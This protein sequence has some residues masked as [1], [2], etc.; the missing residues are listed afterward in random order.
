M[1]LSD[2]IT[3]QYLGKPVEVEDP[4]NSMQCM[5]WAFFACDRMGIPREAIRHL[6]AAQVFN[7]PNTVTRQFF[8]LVP[9][10]SDYVPPANSFA[11]WFANI[12]GLTGIA[13]HIAW[14]LSG[15]TQKT[16]RT[17]DENWNGQLKVTINNHTYPGN[18]N[19]VQMGF[20]VPK[21]NVEGTT[22]MAETVAQLEQRLLHGPG[23]IDEWTNK[24][25]QQGLELKSVQNQLD[26]ARAQVESQQEVINDL[27]KENVAFKDA[28]E[29][30]QRLVKELEAA[31][32]TSAPPASLPNTEPGYPS[33]VPVK[34]SFDLS[35]Y[36]K[37]IIALVGGAVTVATA[38]WGPSN[39]VLTAISTALTALGVYVVPNKESK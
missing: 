23:G 4:S 8:D 39:E 18:D 3:A 25:Y 22:P 28:N 38:I 16:L 2:D 5:D 15:S 14:V 1:A 20:L 21:V 37:T 35:N 30:L 36:K 7:N 26:S 32:Q 17:S 11:V 10:R 24:H 13:G 19:N 27:S 34:P 29:E 12:P 6:Y 9:N 33:E 31:S